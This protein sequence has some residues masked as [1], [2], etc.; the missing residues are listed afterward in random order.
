MT[1]CSGGRYRCCSCCCWQ[2]GCVAQA[3]SRSME[4][5]ALAASSSSEH[6]GHRPRRTPSSEHASRVHSQ[7][8]AWPSMAAKPCR[9]SLGR[10]GGRQR[11]RGGGAASLRLRACQ[12]CCS[13]LLNRASLT[14]WG[15]GS[16][17]GPV[18]WRWRYRRR[19][20]PLGPC[21]LQCLA[22]APVLCP[23]R[24]QPV[25]AEWRPGSCAHGGTAHALWL[26]PVGPTPL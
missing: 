23:P 4:P 10:R 7:C 21:L 25:H 6:R 15:A 14:D 9:G 20:V 22:P 8:L 13:K 17:S 5:D 19:D 18:Q 2:H 11:G 16:C 1:G 3:C 12:A 26:V 24:A